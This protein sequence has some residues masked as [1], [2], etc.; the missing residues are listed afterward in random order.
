VGNTP[1]ELFVDGD[2]QPIKDGDLVQR[3]VCPKCFEGYLE[4]Q[5]RGCLLRCVCCSARLEP[6]DKVPSG[7]CEADVLVLTVSE[8]V[9]TPPMPT[10]KAGSKGYQRRQNQRWPKGR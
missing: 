3:D 2:G 1:S 6:N 4:S 5:G 9:Y 7:R 10:S 8:I